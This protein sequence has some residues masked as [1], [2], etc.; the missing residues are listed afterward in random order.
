[1]NKRKSLV[2]LV[3][4]VLVMSLL[5][6][7]TIEAKKA[8]KLS[9]KKITLK[10]GQKKK[11]KVKNAKKVTWKSS[12]KKIATVSKK[13]VVTAKKAGKVTISA[14]VGKKVLKC[15]VTVKKKTTPKPIKP[16]P[17]KPE[18]TKPTPQPTNPAI[19]PTEKNEET[20]KEQ[21]TIKKDE[22]QEITDN[23]D[24]T[25]PYFSVEN[26]DTK[27][28]TKSVKV[29][30]NINNNPGILGM[31]FAIKYD[32]SV[33][34]LKEAQ[35]GEATKSV[36][37]F[38]PGGV[39]KSGCKFIYDGMEISTSQI[40]DGKILVLTFDISDTAPKGKYPI[41]ISYGEGDIVDN[42]LMPLDVQISNGNIDVK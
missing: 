13:G 6:V 4:L 5:T 23:I 39:L 29:S 22:Q 32:E 28:G 36:L 7:S 11:L 40:K 27:A 41:E 30:V 2:G 8:P 33:M 42:S 21:E 38:T 14:K 16:T 24:R 20:T 25:K 1:M 17:T 15:K 18:P 19:Q 9:N 35:E 37:S 10:V 3:A 12:N 26:V 34:T 31:S